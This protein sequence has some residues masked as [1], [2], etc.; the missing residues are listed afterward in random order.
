MS[1]QKIID[2][3]FEWVSGGTHK[4]YTLA[5]KRQGSDVPS[6]RAVM[7]KKETFYIVTSV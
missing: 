5:I 7:Q 1:T 6:I 2:M 3:G 4:K